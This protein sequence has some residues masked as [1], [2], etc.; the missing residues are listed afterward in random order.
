MR[1]GL[2]GQV[3]QQNASLA[4]ALSNHFLASQGLRSPLTTTLE[5]LGDTLE[6][7]SLMPFKISGLMIAN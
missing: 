5:D 2:Y 6:I 1:L 7:K 3:Q 4:L